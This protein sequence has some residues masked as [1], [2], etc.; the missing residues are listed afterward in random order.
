MDRW[1]SM[2]DEEVHR[3]KVAGRDEKG[4]PEWTFGENP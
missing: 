3:G 1:V 2:K 4:F